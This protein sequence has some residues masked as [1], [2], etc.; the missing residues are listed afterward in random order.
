MSEDGMKAHAAELRAV[1]G[2]TDSELAQRVN[3]RP[4]LLCS[5]P[6]TIAKNIKQLQVQN[7]TSDQAQ[8][9]CASQPSLACLNWASPS[10]LDKLLFFLHVL[11]MTPD[12]ITATPTSLT[13]SLAK[14]VGPRVEFLCRCGLMDPAMPLSH[15]SQHGKIFFYSDTAFLK[16]VGASVR[17]GLV[18]D[19]A[20]KQQWLQ[21]WRYLRQHVGLSVAGIAAH[22]ALLLASLSDTLDPRWRLLT[23][24]EAQQANFVEKDHLS[25]LSGSGSQPVL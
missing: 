19:D 21:R 10:S 15:S 11:H 20:F 17:S 25:F 7:F 2:R 4:R 22:P 6:C 12:D 3:Q 8:H 24:L 13:Y 23:Q 1:L 5:R 9:I 18:Y 14:R 16:S